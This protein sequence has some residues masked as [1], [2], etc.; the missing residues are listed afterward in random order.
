MWE[1]KQTKDLYLKI[2]A[3]RNL[4]IEFTREVRSATDSPLRE[5]GMSLQ[6]VKDLNG[7]TLNRGVQ[8]EYRN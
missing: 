8:I 3:T 1:F 5:R 7:A 4:F 2:V 6:F